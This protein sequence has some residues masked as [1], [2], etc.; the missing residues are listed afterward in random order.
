MKTR[1]AADAR[2]LFEVG[3]VAVWSGV[4]GAAYRVIIKSTFAGEGLFGLVLGLALGVT[5]WGTV[6]G[7]FQ[8]LLLYRRQNNDRAFMLRWLW[9]SVI[10]WGLVG[11]ILGGILVIVAHFMYAILWG[12]FDALFWDPPTW[13]GLLSGIVGSTW[14]QTQVM[15]QKF[16]N[17][18][19]WWQGSLLGWGGG[20]LVFL[21][22]NH[23]PLFAAP[24]TDALSGLAAGI[25]A[26]IITGI[27]LM[28]M[29][30]I[31][32]PS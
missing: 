7:L 4:G 21:G 24:F 32:E 29:T 23:W 11:G 20:F 14:L 5:V 26:G 19:Q 17:S 2:R 16:A 30:M 27:T 13:V 22:L 25:V 15:H 6:Q 31:P 18:R 3:I 10:G 8:S 1:M 9:A 28:R 12:G